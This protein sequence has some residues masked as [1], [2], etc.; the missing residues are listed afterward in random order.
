VTTTHGG[1]GPGGTAPQSG[2]RGT[3]V[4]PTTDQLRPVDWSEWDQVWFPMTYDEELRNLREPQT[5]GGA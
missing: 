5:R 1:E 4:A 2:R 3:P